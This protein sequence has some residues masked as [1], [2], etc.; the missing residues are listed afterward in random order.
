MHS[1]D[2]HANGRHRQYQVRLA[3]LPL[4]NE[5]QRELESARLTPL[6]GL[7]MSSHVFFQ[8]QRSRC[9]GEKYLFNLGAQNDCLRY[10]RRLKQSLQYSKLVIPN[11]TARLSDLTENELTENE[12]VQ[13]AAPSLELL[14]SGK[15]KGCFMFFSIHS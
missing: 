8:M 10:S 5:K 12:L 14:E 11:S 4:K 1:Q 9:C 3:T 13:R 7:T 15:E 6:S 2:G